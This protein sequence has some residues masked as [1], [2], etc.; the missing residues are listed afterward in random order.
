MYRGRDPRRG[1]PDDWE[2]GK[3]PPRGGPAQTRP[4]SRSACCYRMSTPRDADASP[5]R[6]GLPRARAAPIPGFD[7]SGESSAWIT[8]SG[9]PILRLD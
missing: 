9:C 5:H 2:R 4:S 3:Q 6:A 8:L 1:G 7:G